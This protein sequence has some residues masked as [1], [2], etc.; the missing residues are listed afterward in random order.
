MKVWKMIKK[1]ATLIFVFMFF[2]VSYGQEKII[3]VFNPDEVRVEIKNSNVLPKELEGLSWNRWT[4]KNFIVCSLND[5]QA[6][7]LHRHLELVKGWTFARWGMYDID[8][9]VPCKLICVDSKDLFKKLFNLEKTK[10]EI[11]RDSDGR[12]N[13][14]VIFMLIDGPPSQTTPI[15]LTEI[16]LA[17]FAQ[18]YNADFGVWSLKGMSNLNGS[19]EQI[20]E[21]LIQIKPILEKNE[22]LFFSKGILE[23]TPDQYKALSEDKK[24]LF[25]N[26]SIAFC[27]MIRKEFGQDMY[28]KLLQ[29]T[30]EINPEEALIGVLKFKNYEDF[31]KTLKRYYTDLI[32]DIY[33][34]KTPNSYLQIR[35]RVN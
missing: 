29:K 2:N 4:S 35:E 9:S 34:G 12:I 23:M 30:C 17:E 16:C 15:P 31:D 26:C 11:R 32:N 18:K 8:L 27:L 13:E 3:K 7:Y 25:N 10:I 22:P 14:T 33:L 6:Q 20:R 21:K 19:L 28:L 1:T 5:P 24:N